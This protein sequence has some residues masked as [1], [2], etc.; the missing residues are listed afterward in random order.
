MLIYYDVPSMII[1]WF[2]AIWSGKRYII[3]FKKWEKLD[4][5]IKI[6]QIHE[7]EIVSEERHRIFAVYTK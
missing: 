4:E 1:G 6:L 2:T 3:Q 5:G 7:L